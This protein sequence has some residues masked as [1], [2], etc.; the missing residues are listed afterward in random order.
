MSK[1]I[2]KHVGDGATFPSAFHV[3]FVCLVVGNDF[4]EVVFEGVHGGD[5]GVDRA[6]G[7]EIWRWAGR[8]TTCEM[9][10]AL[11]DAHRCFTFV[12]GFGSETVLLC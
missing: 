7:D 11:H 12:S 2:H 10:R 8:G 6:L 5:G 9:S 3:G 4:A 1:F